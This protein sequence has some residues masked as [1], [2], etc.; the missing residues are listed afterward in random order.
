[1][2]Q[3]VRSGSTSSQADSVDRI[4]LGQRF[5]EII[6]LTWDRVDLQRRFI[7]LR[8]IDTKTKK[9]RQVP[10]TSAE[11]ATLADLAKLRRLSTNHVFL[12]QGQPLKGIKTAFTTVKKAAGVTDF[13]FHDLRHCAATNLGR[14]GVDTATAR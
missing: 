1:M 8:S 4:P 11:R 6:Q 7:A 9:P 3:T 5:G 13:R 2:G 12:Y 14:A 10:L